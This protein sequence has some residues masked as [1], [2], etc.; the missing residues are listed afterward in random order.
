MS[1]SAA[2]QLEGKNGRYAFEPSA[3][4]SVNGRFGSV[5][6]GTE[7]GSGH[8]VVIKHFSPQRGT[9]AAAFRFK[10]EALYAFGRPDIQD[11]LDFI[12]DERGLFLVKQYIPGKP[13]KDGSPGPS[14]YCAV[15][16]KRVDEKTRAKT[17]INE[18][19]RD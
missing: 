19:L 14:L 4:L 12:P 13:L 18:L 8:A 6:K 7:T 11:A 1:K 10:T 2:V 17:S 3:G 15:I 16:V 5:Y 9:P